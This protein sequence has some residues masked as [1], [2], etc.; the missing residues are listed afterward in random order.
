MAHDYIEYINKNTNIQYQRPPF[1]LPEINHPDCNTFILFK[2]FLHTLRNNGYSTEHNFI[3]QNY[4]SMDIGTMC[5]PKSNA[6]DGTSVYDIVKFMNKFVSLYE[7]II[8]EDDDGYQITRIK[9]GKKFKNLP[10]FKNPTY[11]S[12]INL[13]QDSDA[14]K[15]VLAKN[16]YERTILFYLPLEDAIALSKDDEDIK[17]IFLHKDVFNQ[18]CFSTNLNLSNASHVLNFL[19]KEFQMNNDEIYDLLHEPDSF[20]KSPIDYLLLSMDVEFHKLK[21]ITKDFKSSFYYMHQDSSSQDISSYSNIY[22]NIL[23][24][25]DTLLKYD[26]YIGEKIHNAITKS[27]DPLYSEIGKHFKEFSDLIYEA[28]KT[29]SDVHPSFLQF[30]NTISEFSLRKKLANFEEENPDITKNKLEKSNKKSKI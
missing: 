16:I 14:K 17:K 25:T 20:N 12:V 5:I 7:P 10:L 19:T 11:S 9:T 13:L 23:N 26:T 21:K 24:T 30:H 18:T 6:F 15:E 2:N 4:V 3:Q 29:N 1:L 28:I 27:N 22:I 8:E